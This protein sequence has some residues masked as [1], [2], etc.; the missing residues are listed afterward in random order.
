MKPKFVIGIAIIFLAVLAVTVFAISGNSN[1]EVKVNEVI[2]QQ[3]QGVDLSER[4][5][6]LT[7]LVVGDSITYDAA[8]LHL[9]FDVVDSRDDLI[10]HPATA[11]RI[12]VVYQ[13]IKPD[14]LVHEAHAIITGKVGQDGKFHAGQ[15]QDALLLQCP[16][17]YENADTASK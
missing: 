7:G 5:L 17:K 15:A 3:A 6:R 16:T 8:T 10:N 13:G 9:E 12:R 11:P 4:A 2:A 14:T 1:L